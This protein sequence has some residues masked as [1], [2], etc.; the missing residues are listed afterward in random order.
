MIRKTSK[1]MASGWHPTTNKTMIPWSILRP[2]GLGCQPFAPGGR[3]SKG[4]LKRMAIS[5][6]LRFEILT[7]DNYTCVYCGRSTFDVELEV[8]HVIPKSKGGSNDPVNLVTACFDCN[9]SKS[10]SLISE[11]KTAD[12]CVENSEHVTRM[13]EAEAAKIK[14][15]RSAKR[16]FNKVIRDLEESLSLEITTLGQRSVRQFLSRLGLDEVVDAACIASAKPTKGDRWR[17]FC[18]VC[19]NK[20]RQIELEGGE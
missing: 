15:M 19:W 2:C 7:R 4:T 14:A 18:G 6:K 17:Y 8:D 16:Q 13:A 12:F 11:S 10:N 20:I 5:K 9:R 1:I 3:F